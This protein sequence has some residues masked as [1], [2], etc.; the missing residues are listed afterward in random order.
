MYDQSA[1]DNIDYCGGFTLTSELFKVVLM[2]IIGYEETRRQAQEQPIQEI[3]IR[4]I[5]ALEACLIFTV[6]YP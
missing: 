4:Q 6:A 5:T 2:D 3:V 1:V